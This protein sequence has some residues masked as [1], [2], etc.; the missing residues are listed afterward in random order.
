MEEQYSKQ[1]SAIPF[2]D[3]PKYTKKEVS[4]LDRSVVYHIRVVVDHFENLKDF[5]A[6]L[7]AFYPYIGWEPW[8]TAPLFYEVKEGGF[9]DHVLVDNSNFHVAFDTGYLMAKREDDIDR[10]LREA[11]YTYKQANPNK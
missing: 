3:L 5:E 4:L 9:L 11:L 10:I 7:K 2:A 8:V 1:L 6:Y